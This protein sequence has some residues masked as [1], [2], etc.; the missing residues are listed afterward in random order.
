[1]KRIIFL[2]FCNFKYRCQKTK[3]SSLWDQD[4]KQSSC[5]S[6]SI[7]IFVLRIW[8]WHY[9]TVFIYYSVQFSYSRLCVLCIV[10][11]FYFF[12]LIKEYRLK[13]YY[14]ISLGWNVNKIWI[15]PVQLRNLAMFVFNPLP[16][17]NNK[18]SD[19]WFFSQF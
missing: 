5:L 4:L 2:S 1:M 7:L 11:T 15:F 12:T 14:C 3:I 8:C 18:L 19:K 10:L 9:K 6:P 13:I 16:E 17:K